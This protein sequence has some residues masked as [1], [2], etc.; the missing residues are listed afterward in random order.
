MDE[1]HNKISAAVR[2]LKQ[3]KEKISTK[4]KRLINSSINL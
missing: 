1:V 4:S 2:C 3:I